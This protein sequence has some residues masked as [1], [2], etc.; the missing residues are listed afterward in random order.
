M[1][2]T[3]GVDRRARRA[4]MSQASIEAKRGLMRCPAC[5]AV[6]DH[7]LRGFTCTLTRCPEIFVY[8]DAPAGPAAAVGAPG[9]VVTK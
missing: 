4:Q 8:L 1:V 9:E 3:K 7:L 2:E 5:S 6:K